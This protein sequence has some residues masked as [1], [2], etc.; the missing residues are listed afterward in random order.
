M[1]KPEIAQLL[2]EVESPYS[3]VVAIARRS[4]D[5]ATL[6]EEKKIDLDDKP[7]NVAISEFGARRLKIVAKP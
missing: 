4:R 3:L 6:S 5:L 1:L 7:V 2:N